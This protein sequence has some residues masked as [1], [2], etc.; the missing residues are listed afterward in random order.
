[1]KQIR[2]LNPNTPFEEVLDRIRYA[3]SIIELRQVHQTLIDCSYY[4]SCTKEQVQLLQEE[5][6]RTQRILLEGYRNVPV[7]DFLA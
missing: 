4:L 5:G 2:S 1:M 7:D 3:H 6:V